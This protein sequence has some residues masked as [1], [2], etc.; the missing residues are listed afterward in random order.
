M[1]HRRTLH[2]TLGIGLLTLLVLTGCS[3]PTTSP[4]AQQ[5]T[6]Q[7]ATL[8][9]PG[10]LH[11]TK[12]SGTAVG[13]MFIKRNDGAHCSTAFAVTGNRLLTAA[14]CDP[15]HQHT[16]K[17]GG[18]PLTH[19]PGRISNDHEALLLDSARPTSGYLLTGGPTSNQAIPVTGTT[20]VT[21]GMQ[22][23]TS[24]GNSGAH[25][26][27]EVTSIS[28]ERNG[29]GCRHTCTLAQARILSP[30][31]EPAIASGDSGGALYALSPDGT[32]L[33]A[34]IISAIGGAIVDCPNTLNKTGNPPDPRHPFKTKNLV[35]C[36][37]T[38]TFSPIEPILKHY[39]IDVERA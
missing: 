22:L 34:G 3:T 38:V 12:P 11:R 1:R 15:K 31:K 36:A 4:S 9:I 39:N 23:C 33:A 7:P 2:P 16:W 35:A 29:R 8:P 32:A 24:G 30:S 14:H 19:H 37:R 10:D 27:L 5:A 17:Q 28:E 26:P 18:K 6:Q 20:P 13:G 25:C 21:V